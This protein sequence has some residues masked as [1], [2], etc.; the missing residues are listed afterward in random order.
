MACGISLA[1]LKRRLVRAEKRFLKAARDR[2]AI[3]N[4]IRA[5]TTIKRRA[6]ERNVTGTVEPPLRSVALIDLSPGLQREMV[7]PEPKEDASIRGYP[8]RHPP[9]QDGLATARR[10]WNR[11]IGPRRYDAAGGQLA[12]P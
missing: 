10:K 1:T 9:G 3:E 7:A 12:D 2:E 4:W 6:R 11:D 8:G 5:G